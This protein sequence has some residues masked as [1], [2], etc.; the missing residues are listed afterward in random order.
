MRRKNEEK[1]T[2]IQEEPF[3]WQARC[4]GSLHAKGL[5]LEGVLGFKKPV[6]WVVLLLVQS[7]VASPKAQIKHVVQKIGLPLTCRRGVSPAQRALSV[8]GHARN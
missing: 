2:G 7:V 5:N 8:S 1:L 4:G 3:N 6:G